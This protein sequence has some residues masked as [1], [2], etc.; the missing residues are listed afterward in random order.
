MGPV[1]G[2]MSMVVSPALKYLLSS[3]NL[4]ANLPL[5]QPLH[6]VK[7]SLG[8]PAAGPPEAGIQVI[9]LGFNV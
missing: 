8:R 2:I 9:G 1:R 4:Q 5:P 3:M 7:S 6:P